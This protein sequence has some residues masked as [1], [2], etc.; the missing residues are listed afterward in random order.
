MTTDATSREPSSPRPQ[1][2]LPNILDVRIRRIPYQPSELRYFQSYLA[3]YQEAIEFLVKTDGPI[4]IGGLSP[5]LYVGDMEVTESEGVEEN[6]YRFLAFEFDQL[7]E[8]ASISLGW[9]NQPKEQRLETKFRYK[10]PD[11]DQKK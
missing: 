11:Y 10:L 2:K 9:P 7:K 5:V 6:A 8:G 3:K 1:W 4:P